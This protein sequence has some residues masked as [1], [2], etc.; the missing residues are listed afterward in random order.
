MKN[1]PYK[2][3]LKSESYRKCVDCAKTGCSL[4]IEL[5]NRN[6]NQSI[7]EPDTMIQKKQKRKSFVNWNKQKLR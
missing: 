3:F 2:R 7:N 6:Q 5:F 4:P 1:D